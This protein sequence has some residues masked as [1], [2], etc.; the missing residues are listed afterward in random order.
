[1]GI[2][3]ADIGGTNARFVYADADRLDKPI[4][5]ASYRCAEFTSFAAVFSQF[6][7]DSQA[8]KTG[9]EALALAFPGLVDGNTA[10]LT[11]LPWVV[12]K[13]DLQEKF[14]LKQ[15]R[16]L[17]DFE[18]AAYGISRLKIGDMLC[19][20]Q[21]ERQEDATKAIVGAGT[22]LG[23]SWLSGVSNQIKAHATEGGHIDFA[24]TDEM[25]L[26]LLK[27]MLERYE[28]VSYERVLSGPGLIN[29]YEF[30]AAERDEHINP[31]WISTAAEKGEKKA[32]QAMQ[33]FVRIYGGYVGNIALIFK[34]AGG[35]YIAGG[36]ASK[37][38]QWMQSDDF[39]HA[40]LNK[41]RMQSL[42]NQFSVYLVTNER[43][44]LM[45]AL[46]VA[47]MTQQVERK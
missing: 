21:G 29:L 47:A 25:Q 11:N 28:H 45:G 37:I 1:M 31:A 46:S 22:G 35:I 12:D 16:F 39:L 5:S 30:C 41:G 4:F 18:A 44:G 9:I 38:I 20:N 24:P 2:I 3:G 34:P 32:Q 14:G 40:Y 23:L 13:A 43:I 8:K 26:E 36:I 42:V 27:F 17:N 19:L 7:D 10:R 15:V 33:L 6:V